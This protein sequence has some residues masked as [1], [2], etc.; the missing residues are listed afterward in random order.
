MDTDLSLMECSPLCQDIQLNQFNYILPPCVTKTNGPDENNSAS[1]K[2]KKF[3]MERNMNQVPEWK[4]CQTESWDSV[5]LNKTNNS[6]MLSMGCRACLKFQVKGVCYS[7]CCHK[8]SHTVLTREDKV[9][10]TN[11]IKVLLK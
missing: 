7:D 11:F 6:P 3:D 4:L 10:T 9:K 1:S 2:K 8:N 5:F